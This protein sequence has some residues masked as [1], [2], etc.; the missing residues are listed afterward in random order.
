MSPFIAELKDD[1]I[2]ILTTLEEIITVGIRSNE[3]QQK[4]LKIK[5]ALLAHLKKEDEK[6]YPPLEEVAKTDK[7]LRVTLE[8]FAQDMI[9]T[10]ELVMAFFEKYNNPPQ[11]L[12]FVKDFG[13]LYALLNNRIRK[14]ENILY[15][16]YEKL[17]TEQKNKHGAAI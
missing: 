3:G 2:L 4:L 9:K 6:L 8:I 12:E 7:N 13:K 16:E 11:S 1:H 10:S 5:N 15:A 17:P 14:E